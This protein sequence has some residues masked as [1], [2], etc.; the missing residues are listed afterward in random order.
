MREVKRIIESQSHR[1]IEQFGLEETFKDHLVHPLPRNEKGQL[2]LD[3][4]AQSPVQPDL[5]CFQA[6]GIYHPSG[7]LFPV[8]H[9]PH[10]KKLLPYI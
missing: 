10:W 1:I 5:G 8:L 6:W 7:Q 9:H 3:Q 4:A 2:Q